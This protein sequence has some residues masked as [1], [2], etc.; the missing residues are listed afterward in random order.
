MF[1][2]RG[3]W[4]EIVVCREKPVA[5]PAKAVSEDFAMKI[6]GVSQF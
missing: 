6:M 3:Q 1:R 2:H 5:Q 4:D